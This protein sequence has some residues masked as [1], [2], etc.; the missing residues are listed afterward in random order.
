MVFE[1]FAQP[2]LATKS[3]N[4]IPEI[5]LKSEL[6][7]FQLLSRREPGLKDF[8]DLPLPVS[9]PG[10]TQPVSQLYLDKK[11]KPWKRIQHEHCNGSIHYR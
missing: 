2:V 4:R 7:C 1:H 8:L 3:H 6:G 5:Q 9:T 10:H 11:G